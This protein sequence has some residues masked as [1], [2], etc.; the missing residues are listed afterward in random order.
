M[1]AQK[2]DMFI[3]M[4]GKYLEYSQ[5]PKIKQ[6]LLTVDESTW[7]AIEFLQFKDPSTSLLVSIFGGSLGIDRF[8]IGHTGLGVAKLLTCGG[9]YIW[10]IVD[11]FLIQNAT[12]EVNMQKLREAVEFS[13]IR[14]V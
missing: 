13:R 11:W 6:Y 12:R 14:N 1:D 3:M 4:N 5:L 10:T 9:L 7:S 2:V 8:Y